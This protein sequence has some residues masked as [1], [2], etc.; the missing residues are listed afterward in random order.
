M[1]TIPL[2]YSKF[3]ADQKMATHN[4]ITTLLCNSVI[5]AAVGSGTMEVKSNSAVFD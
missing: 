4:N 5:C 2:L 3:T 1:S